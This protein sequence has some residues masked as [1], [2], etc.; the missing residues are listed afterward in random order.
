[1]YKLVYGEKEAS[2]MKR[3]WLKTFWREF[4]KVRFVSIPSFRDTIGTSYIFKPFFFFFN[5]N[6]E[7]FDIRDGRGKYLISFRVRSI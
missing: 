2:T 5:I 1:M 7:I 3:R 4:I 6:S